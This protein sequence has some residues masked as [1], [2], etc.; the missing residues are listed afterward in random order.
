MEN[1]LQRI[2]KMTKRYSEMI[3]YLPLALRILIITFVKRLDSGKNCLVII[4]GRTGSGKSWAACAILY[5]C[6]LYMN[7][8]EPTTE[9][10]TSCWSF[11]AKEFVEKMGNPELDIKGLNLWD[12]VGPSM[13][14]KTHQSVQN[15]VVSFL[16]QT[17]RNLQQLVVFTVPM[18][19]FVDK[20]VRNLLHYQIETR[21]INLKD[22]ICIVKPLE[23]DYN[24]RMDK[25][26]Y[27]N[28]TSPSNDGSGLINEVDVAGIPAP[29]KYIT[30]T[31]E[32]F[33]GEFK[34]GLTKELIAR[35]ARLEE[36]KEFKAL[37][38]QELII[39][40][41][42]RK[43]GRKGEV[44]ECFERGIF[45][46]EEIAKEIGI[47]TQNLA[48]CFQGLREMGINIPNSPRKSEF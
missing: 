26:F 34:T 33:A 48:M 16:V 6:F 18:A 21:H 14:H 32:K 10:M 8:R 23:L 11:K 35:L 38:G 36:P 13:S 28:L 40:K 5:Y 24:V 20:S 37:S 47:T 42:K 7:G 31:Y 22:K 17:F 15:R 4:V 44:L 25:M 19:S 43:G 46:K 30:D 41:Q 1:N 9:E 12:D 3:A 27:H 2:N 39:A 45:D 29:P